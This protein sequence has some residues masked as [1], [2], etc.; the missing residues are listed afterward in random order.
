MDSQTFQRPSPFLN[1]LKLAL[2]KKIASGSSCGQ[3]I[4]SSFFKQPVIATPFLTLLVTPLPQNKAILWAQAAC[5]IAVNMVII[6][7]QRPMDSSIL[8]DHL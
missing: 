1:V 3:N 6:K 4:H 7:E 8:I 2:F 5:W